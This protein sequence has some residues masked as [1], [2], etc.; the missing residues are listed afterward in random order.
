MA[1]PNDVGVGAMAAVMIID[2]SQPLD[3]FRTEEAAQDD[4]DNDDTGDP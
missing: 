3:R 4:R 2:R 1:A